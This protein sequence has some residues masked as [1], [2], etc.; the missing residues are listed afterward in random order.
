MGNLDAPYTSMTVQA[1]GYE[2]R[3]IR[4]YHSDGDKETILLQPS[5]GVP[6]AL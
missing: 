6:S 4:D 2:T 5:H 3:E 1:A